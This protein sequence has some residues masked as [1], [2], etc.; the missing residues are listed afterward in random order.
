LK[1]LHTA[2]VHLTK[3]GD[4]RWAALQTILAVGKKENIDV[5][6]ISGDLFDERLDVDDLRPKLRELFS[7]NGFDIVLISGNHDC[8][9]C[10]DLY[11]GSD[12][13]VL[14]DLYKPYENQSTRIWGLPFDN[15]SDQQLI[16]KLQ[17]LKGKLQEE[18]TNILLY[19]GELL[20]CLFSR[21]DFGEEGQYRYMPLKL[22]YFEDLSINYV[23]AGHFHSSFDVRALKNGG[24]FV[25][26]G[27]P[28]S[29][30]RK[31]CQV[32]AVNLFEVGKDPMPYGLETFHYAEKMLTL[33]P[34]KHIQPLE[35][36]QEILQ[37]A[38][39]L[40]RVLLTVDGYFDREKIGMNENEL[41]KAITKAV[42][43]NVEVGFQ[44][45]DIHRIF[46]DDI[47]KAYVQ[48]VNASTSPDK[49]KKE[50]IDIAIRSFMEAK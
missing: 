31:E 7:N 47:F 20:D 34:F 8:N 36:I 29:I 14:S 33:D 15:V 17:R 37:N 48:K 43:K 10:T 19:H 41:L 12:V 13:K 35:V 24:F 38:S 2:D 27:S 6:A 9:V 11:F 50:L 26:P 3:F 4:E 21:K 32:R 42:G 23:L 25:Y 44:A 16:E 39:P 40:E 18:Y 45:T 1:I 22:A 30:T 5:L 28:V 46:E 49:K